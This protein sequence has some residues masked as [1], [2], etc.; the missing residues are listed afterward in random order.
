MIENRCYP[1]L[2]YVGFMFISWIHQGNRNHVLGKCLEMSRQGIGLELPK[3]IPVG[4]PITVRAGWLDLDGA[5]TVR[6][7][8]RHQGKYLLGIELR[9]ALQPDIWDQ[10]VAA[11]EPNASATVPE[12]VGHGS[13]RTEHTAAS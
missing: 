2:R 5:A 4:T 1:R 7:S 8:S 12:E 3:C 10:I 11:Q 13:L 9:E 6:H